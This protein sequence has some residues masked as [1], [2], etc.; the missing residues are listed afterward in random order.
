M[1]S[2]LILILSQV[3]EKGYSLKVAYVI[4]DD[5]MDGIYERLGDTGGLRHLD[6]E[7]PDVV[8]NGDSGEGR[9]DWSKYPIVSANAYTGARAIKIG[10]DEGADIICCKI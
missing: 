8:L 9:K 2:I 10:L 5:L 4:G 3:Q 1:S 7:N 6:A